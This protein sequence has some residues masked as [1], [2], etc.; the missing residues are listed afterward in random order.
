MQRKEN[1]RLENC[2]H[3][4]YNECQQNISRDK[5]LVG[6][7]CNYSLSQQ[8]RIF[9]MV[10]YK[11]ACE[12]LPIIG[13]KCCG[14]YIMWSPSILPLKVGVISRNSQLVDMCFM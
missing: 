12:F 11:S 3:C 4:H 7:F 8:Y 2:L 13:R 1:D 14:L 5:L 6:P 9:E 10:D